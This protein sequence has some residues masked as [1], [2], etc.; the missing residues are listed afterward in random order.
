MWLLVYLVSIP[1]CHFK[2][3]DWIGELNFVSY[4]QFANTTVMRGIRLLSIMEDCLK[5]V[6]SCKLFCFR[7]ISF[8]FCVMGRSTAKF[9][10]VAK[11]KWIS[12]QKNWRHKFAGFTRMSVLGTFTTFILFAALTG[13][14]EAPWSHLMTTGKKR[15][16]K[17]I[18]LRNLILPF[19]N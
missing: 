8:Q 19:F 1:T 4:L 15:L 11:R 9:S 10:A 14:S 6:T 18:Y 16:L 2:S 17:G 3:W 7:I 13:C 5:L 12:T